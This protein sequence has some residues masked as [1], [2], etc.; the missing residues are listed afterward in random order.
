MKTDPYWWEAAPRPAIAPAD[1][2]AKADVV[3]VGSGYTGLVA[4]LKLAEAG[5]HIVVLDAGEIG[6][7]ASSR[8]AGFV[9]R[10]LKYSFGDLVQAKSLA[11]LQRFFHVETSSIVLYF[12]A[13]GV[14]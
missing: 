13:E 6:S 14:A 7:G 2:P 8:N 10:T 11:I 3:I 1:L 5:R 4:A 9:G 12:E